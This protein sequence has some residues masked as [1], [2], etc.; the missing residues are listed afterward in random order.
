MSLTAAFSDIEIKQA[1][2]L[3]HLS[4]RPARVK[5]DI[6]VWNG[7]LIDRST[8]IVTLLKVNGSVPVSDSVKQRMYANYVQKFGG[9]PD[10]ELGKQDADSGEDVEI[11]ARVWFNRICRTVKGAEERTNSEIK[12]ILIELHTV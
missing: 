5:D 4:G 1:K 2:L 12:Q 10:A 8:A 6:F 7:H 9:Y 11:L 3:S